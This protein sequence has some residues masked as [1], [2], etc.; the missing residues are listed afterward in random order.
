MGRE[1]D[2]AVYRLAEAIRSGESVAVREMLSA[3]AAAVCDS[4][5]LLPALTG[6]FHGAQD[7]ARLVRLIGSVFPHAELTVEAVNGRSGLLMRQAAGE[8]VAVIAV[9]AG[10]TGISAPW[11]VLNQDKL[12][13][14]HCFPEPC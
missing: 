7:V 5:G 13:R 11:I 10:E 3:E 2:D 1:S 14:W 9:E 12:S 6:T 8:A 4:A